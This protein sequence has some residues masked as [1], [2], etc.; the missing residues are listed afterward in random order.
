MGIDSDCQGLYVI[1]H[2]PYVILY[3]LCVILYSLYFMLHHLCYIT[4]YIFNITRLC[5][6]SHHKKEIENVFT[7][8]MKGF[9]QRVNTYH[10]N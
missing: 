1:L 7:L 6:F 3:S 2:S 4:Q 8:D 9:G 10:P 5:Y